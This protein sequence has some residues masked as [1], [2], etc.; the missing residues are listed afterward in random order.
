M[1]K[2]TSEEWYNEIP[3]NFR[4]VIYDPDGWDRTN[5]Q[6]SFHEELITKEEFLYRLSKSTVLSNREA[7]EWLADWK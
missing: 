6:Y 7:F 4:L 3:E 5:Y 2:K 1:E